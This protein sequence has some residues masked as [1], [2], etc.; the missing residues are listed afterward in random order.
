MLSR[1]LYLEA[2]GAGTALWISVFDVDA[3]GTR[4]EIHRTSGASDTYLNWK[5]RVSPDNGRTWGEFEA[6]EDVVQDLPGGGLVRYAGTC[7]FDAEHARRYEPVMRRLWPGAKPYSWEPKSGQQHLSDH[8]WVVED[9]TDERMMRWEEGPEFDP[10]NPF[11]P[12]F[13]STNQLYTGSGMAFARDGTVYYPNIC[14]RHA[15]HVMRRRGGLVLMRRE[16]EGGQWLPSNQQFI[17]EEISS[18]GLLEPD[19]AVLSTGTILIVCR[20]S[21]TET[22][23]GRK[24]MC[25][26][27]DGGKTISAPEELRYDDGSRFYSPSSIHRFIRSSRNGKL[28]WIANIVPEPPGGNSPRYPLQIAEIDEETPAVKKSSLVVVDEKGK[29]DSE[30]LH[31]SNFSVIEDVETKDLEIYITRVGED[32]ED[33]WRSGVYR[34]RFSPP[35]VTGVAGRAPC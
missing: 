19:V 30:R 24:W 22:T 9:G 16:P 21:N 26:S 31:L 7:F 14:F 6:L 33:F 13:C 28:Y 25:R 10:E 32:P 23:A 17:G 4:Q 29:G 12:Q 8:V 2:P 11:D 15:G 5:R 20:G 34:Y 35:G 1:E 18:R 27:D 3:E